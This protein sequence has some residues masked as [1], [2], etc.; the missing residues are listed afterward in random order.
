M[1]AFTGVSVVSMI[2]EERRRSMG[3]CLPGLARCRYKVAVSIPSALCEIS[4]SLHLSAPVASTS[5]SSTSIIH[6]DLPPRSSTLIFHLPPRS[7]TLIS[8]HFQVLPTFAAQILPWDSSGA[9]CSR[10]PSIS[11]PRLHPSSHRHITSTSSAASR[12]LF[13]RAP[14]H[15]PA[16]LSERQRRPWQV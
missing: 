10:I 8:S 14:G 9:L 15:F 5:P 13:P 12:V 1:E 7:S 2:K 6:L 11:R 3:A 4:Y 16:P